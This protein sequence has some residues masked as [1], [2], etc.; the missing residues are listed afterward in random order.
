MSIFALILI[1]STLLLIVSQFGSRLAARNSIVWWAITAFIIIS[2]FRPELWEP[3]TRMLGITLVSNFLLAALSMFLFLQLIELS[4][5]TTAQ[6][7]KTRDLTAGLAAD[8]YARKFSGTRQDRN[9]KRTKV[10]V[11]L[12]CYN[13]EGI[14]RETIARI[15]E[16]KLENERRGKF[17]LKICVVNDGSLDRSEEILI[18]NCY[19]DFVSHRVNIGVAGVLLTGFKIGHRIQADYVVQCDSDGQH[20]IHSILDLVEKAM[21]GRYDLLIG[22][23]F[24][25]ITQGVENTDSSTT[26]AR[27]AGIFIIRAMLRVFGGSASIFDPTSGFR[28][29][30]RNAQSI[31]LRNMPDEYPEPESVAIL[32]LNRARVAEVSVNMTPRTTGISS[33]NGIKTFRFMVKVLTALLGLRLRS[34]VSG[35]ATPS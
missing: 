28:A 4:A 11:V 31:L 25:P 29:Y 15:N 35:R 7:R 34:L 13:E 6:S 30:S 12:P 3:V 27:I 18:D 24:V 9:D 19:N 5:E 10:L 33:I 21:A 23:R 22:S 14:I 2:S 1:C 26:Q 32:A 17:D 16:L 20:P 8:E